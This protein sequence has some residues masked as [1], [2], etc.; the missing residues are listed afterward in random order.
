GS[1]DEGTQRGYRQLSNRDADGVSTDRDEQYRGGGSRSIPPAQRQ[2]YRCSAGHATHVLFG[3][4][5]TRNGV[6]ANDFGDFSLW[7]QSRH[8]GSPDHRLAGGAHGVSP[9]IAVAGAKSDD[10]LYEPHNR[11][12]IAEPPF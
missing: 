3:R 12:R 11:R 7:R 2:F 4:C 10:T 6:D 1:S 5:R 8:S 9:A